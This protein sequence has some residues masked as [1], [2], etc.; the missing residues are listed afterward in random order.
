ML[1]LVAFLG[2]LFLAAI[3]APDASAQSSGPWYPCHQYSGTDQ[4][5][6][7]R[8]IDDFN[9]SAAGLASGSFLVGQACRALSPGLDYRPPPLPRAPQIRA[10]PSFSSS[11]SSSSQPE[12]DPRRRLSS[13]GESEFTRNLQRTYDRI[14]RENEADTRERR[15]GYQSEFSRDLQ[16]TYDQLRRDREAQARERRESGYQSEFSRNLQRTYAD[17]QRRNE[18]EMEERRANGYQTE[19]SRNLQRT[20][21]DIQR[22]N[23]AEME[24]RR[25]NGYQTEFSRNLQQTYDDIRRDREAGIGPGQSRRED[26]PR[27]SRRDDNPSPNQSLE[28]SREDYYRSFDRMRR[29]DD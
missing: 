28:Q 19:F 18:A 11:S 7:F 6:C 5:R 9:C 23:E 29:D 8:R 20:Y 25:A 10:R 24:E 2:V 27:Q 16:R 3:A 12:T 17:I 14:Q 21:A 22:R 1:R 15:N 4:E 26:A 13:S